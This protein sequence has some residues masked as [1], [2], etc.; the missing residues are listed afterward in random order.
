MEPK[1]KP[2]PASGGRSNGAPRHH[3]PDSRHGFPR[4]D[5]GGYSRHEGHSHNRFSSNTDSRFGNTAGSVNGNRSNTGNGGAPRGFGGGNETRSFAPRDGAGHPRSSA[6]RNS[7]PRSGP[8]AGAQ[9]R[10]A[11]VSSR[12]TRSGT[13]NTN[14]NKW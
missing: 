13:G 12:S 1:F 7:A 3:A 8:G 9:R 10:P 11:G 5:R 4:D 6:P 2:R 14:G